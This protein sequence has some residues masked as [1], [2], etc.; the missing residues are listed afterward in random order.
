MISLK[1]WKQNQQ[2]HEERAI[3]RVILMLYDP[4]L[5]LCYSMTGAK[6]S[7]GDLS[8]PWG[9]S[10]G[11][12]YFLLD[13]LL[14]W[15]HEERDPAWLCIRAEGDKQRKIF[16]GDI[17]WQIAIMD[18]IIVLDTALGWLE[19][20]P[21]FLAPWNSGLPFNLFR[22]DLCSHG[23][24]SVTGVQISGL[25]GQTQHQHHSRVLLQHPPPS[26][27]RWTA[28]NFRFPQRN[29]TYSHSKK[30]CIVAKVKAVNSNS[31]DS[32]KDYKPDLPV[33][34]EASS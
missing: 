11:R 17:V 25:E 31:T 13:C 32:E 30:M 26:R 14:A 7:A 4:Q 29:G 16:W 34:W 27:L 12:R 22:V 20:D 21:L 5:G 33:W 8:T 24:S 10:V 3:H 28:S 15:S 23:T 18:D 9:V 1:D 19:K 2:I 6:T